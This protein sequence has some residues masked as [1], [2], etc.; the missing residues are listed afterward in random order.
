MNIDILNE[1]IISKLFLLKTKNKQKT[2]PQIYFVLSTLV[3][4]LIIKSSF[5]YRISSIKNS[6]F[7]ARDVAQPQNTFTGLSEFHPSPHSYLHTHVETKSLDVYVLLKLPSYFNV[8]AP[9]RQCLCPRKPVAIQQMMIQCTDEPKAVSHPMSTF[10]QHKQPKPASQRKK[11]T[12][13][14]KDMQ[15]KHFTFLK[16]QGLFKLCLSTW[17]Q[18]TIFTLKTQ[19]HTQKK[20]K[21][22][23]GW[24][25]T[26]CVHFNSKQVYK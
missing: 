15:L 10:C 7:K 19:D 6:I 11:E 14:Y 12:R 16:L 21:A 24:V 22:G 4:P 23:Q 18:R 5:K 13:R 26:G 9:T 2:N 8:H 17:S 25:G 3:N 20:K 1:D